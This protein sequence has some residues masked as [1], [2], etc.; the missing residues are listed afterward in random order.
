MSTM[1]SGNVALQKSW[2][3]GT[4]PAT[5]QGARSRVKFALH[6]VAEEKLTAN[7]VLVVGPQHGFELEQLGL[8][9][10]PEFQGLELVPDYAASCREKGFTCIEGPA[11][12]AAELVEG[13]WN[14]YTCHSLEH[15]YDVQAAVD[16]IRQVC[17]SWCFVAV[18]IEPGTTPPKDKAHLSVFRTVEQVKALFSPWADLRR[19]YSNTGGAGKTDF[20]ALYVKKPE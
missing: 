10:V 3:A 7:R 1:P 9:E 20:R 16:A 19:E 13:R 14:I 4:G 15:T 8:S 18:P 2:S 12:R 11:E 6:W 17:L 5:Q